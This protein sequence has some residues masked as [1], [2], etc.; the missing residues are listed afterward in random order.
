MRHNRTTVCL[1]LTRARARS[2][3]AVFDK[4]AILYMFTWILA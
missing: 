3:T 4:D 2:V 1:V